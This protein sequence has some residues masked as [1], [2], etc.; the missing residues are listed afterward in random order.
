MVLTRVVSCARSRAMA[1]SSA[2]SSSPWLG[3]S[4]SVRQYPP[5]GPR[6]LT[7]WPAVMNRFI[8]SIAAPVDRPV[9]SQMVAVEPTRSPAAVWATSS[10]TTCSAISVL[11]GIPLQSCNYLRTTE[12]YS[13]I[14]DM[15]PDNTDAPLT[16]YRIFDVVERWTGSGEARF[17]AG[18]CWH[19]GM[20]IAHCVQIRNVDTGEVH[21]V[22][23]TCAERVGLSATDLRRFLAEKFSA[24]RSARAEARRQGDAEAAAAAE[25]ATEAMYG[26]HGSESRFASGC[27][28]NECRAVAPHGITQ[29]PGEQDRR[30]VRFEAGCRCLDCIDAAIAVS[31]ESSR[32]GRLRIV[33]DFDVVVELSTGE[34]VDDARIVSGQYGLSW[35]IRGGA[36][37]MTV[38]PRR[39]S[40]QA[41]K[42]F[43][44]ATAPWLVRESSPR[45]GRPS[46]IDP[47]A[48]IGSPIVDAWGEPIPRPDTARPV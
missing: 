28:C 9:A 7:T 47:I 43:V 19:C 16:R 4:V 17:P 8:T 12:Q 36:T 37:W 3:S 26:I 20:A 48:P 33:E 18:S 39:R 34:V 42:G 2:R 30:A 32:G 14:A 38:T 29:R 1:V 22:G 15:A 21:E 24:E 41:N 45:A 6:V 23:T 10:R 5:F 35:C 27:D 40:T 31:A 13:T 46:F 44:E 11:D 25:V